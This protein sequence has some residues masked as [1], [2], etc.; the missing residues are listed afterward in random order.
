MTVSRYRVICHV[1]MVIIGRW[2]RISI[3]E[4]DYIYKYLIP[5]YKFVVEVS[6]RAEFDF[7]DSPFPSVSC[8]VH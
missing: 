6:F 1:F 8:V 4:K 3:H 5:K 2:N 7:F